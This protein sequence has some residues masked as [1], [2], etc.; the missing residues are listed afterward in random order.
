MGNPFKKPKAQSS[1]Q[2][3]ESSPWA[4]AQ[5]SLKDILNEMQGWYGDAKDTGYISETGDLGGIY[6]DYLAGLN[7]TQG[8]LGK[9]VQDYLGQSKDYQSQAGNIFGQMAQ[10]GMNLT[11]EQ[12]A[13]N[14]AKLVD[15]ELV[16][17]QIGAATGDIYDNLGESLSMA[18]RGNVSGGN[19]GSSRAAIADAAMSRDAGKL[20]ANTSTAIRAQATNDALNRAGQMMNQNL[21]TQSQGAGQLAGLGSQSFGQGSQLGQMLNQGNQL[22]LQGA[23][24]KQM[25]QGAAQADKIGERDYLAD[26]IGQYYAPIATGIGGM[27][28]TSTGTMRQPGSANAGL[29]GLMGVGSMAGGLMQGL[30]SLGFSDIRLK[31]DIELIGKDGDLNIYRWDW[32]DKGKEIVGDQPNYGV[33]AQEIKEAYPEAV[34]DNAEHGYLMVDYDKLKEM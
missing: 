28:G 9:G 23:Q 33:M 14:A 27:G 4:P 22:G 7:K 24:I 1:T 32:N 15:N 11:P 3:T 29:S 30:G 31:N 34:I 17:S 5:D 8:E 12:L 25:L 21:Q 18:N 6:G 10:G 19:V 2:K 16:Q 20:A 13:E 26:L